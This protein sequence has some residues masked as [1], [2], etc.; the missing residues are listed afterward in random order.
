MVDPG[1]R[2][3][4]DFTGIADARLAWQGNATDVAN[5]STVMTINSNKNSS[6]GKLGEPIGQKRFSTNNDADGDPNVEV[7]VD[8]KKPQEEDV[9]DVE[10]WEEYTVV[11]RPDG[12]YDIVKFITR[13]ERTK[14][15]AIDDDELRELIWEMIVDK[16]QVMLAAY[17]RR[18]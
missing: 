4:G 5:R 16:Y 17:G 8:A 3:P 12:G 2:K 10:E 1:A 9:T 18:A 7:D 13:T 14:I 15:S 11:I 6:E